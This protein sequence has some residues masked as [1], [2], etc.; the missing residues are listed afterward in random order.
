[1][2]AVSTNNDNELLMIIQDLRK[3]IT[4]LKA[5]RDALQAQ[6]NEDVPKLE[7]E[8]DELIKFRGNIL[9]HFDLLPNDVKELVMDCELGELLEDALQK[10]F[11]EQSCLYCTDGVTDAN[12]PCENCEEQGDEQ[13]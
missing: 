5:E 7:A 4:Q 1:M 13:T 9:D 11:K 6:Y 10:I 3:E 8:R 12:E 2:S